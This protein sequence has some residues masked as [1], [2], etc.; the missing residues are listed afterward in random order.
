M[1]EKASIDEAFILC[2][3]GAAQM[4]ESSGECSGTIAVDRPVHAQFARLVIT[5]SSVL[6]DTLN[7]TADRA[8][9]TGSQPNKMQATTGIP[10]K[11]AAPTPRVAM[12][13]QKYLSRPLVPGPSDA[14]LQQSTRAM[15]CIVSLC[16]T[17]VQSMV[18]NAQHRWKHGVLLEVFV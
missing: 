13:G 16:R 8:Q 12:C 9:C 4:V 18:S 11:P 7:T 3:T 6:S 14:M 2:R 17:R 15:V 5:S 10:P 1:I